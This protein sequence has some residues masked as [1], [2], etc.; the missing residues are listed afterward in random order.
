LGGLK[1][2]GARRGGKR[3]GI[4]SRGVLGK[5][6]ENKMDKRGNKD[7]EQTGPSE[8]REFRIRCPFREAKGG[9]WR[10]FSVAEEGEG[11]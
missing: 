4:A 3:D 7:R 11:V 8:S 6:L 9:R 5:F 10:E 2:A 1:P